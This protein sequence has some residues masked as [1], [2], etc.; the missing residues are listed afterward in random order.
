VRR[1]ARHALLAYGY[2]RGRKRSQLEATWPW[3]DLRNTTPRLIVD[4]VMK[5]VSRFSG[6]ADRDAI[7]AWLKD[8]QAA[9]AA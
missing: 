5:N 3:T 7:E 9:K 4:G 2:L 1:A 8:E 6:S